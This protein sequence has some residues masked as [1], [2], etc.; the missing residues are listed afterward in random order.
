MKIKE[1]LQEEF[2]CAISSVLGV[3]EDEEY[4]Q[5]KIDSEDIMAIA[6]K[7]CFYLDM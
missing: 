3:L 1:K 4:S 6:R 5:E 2:G 7:V